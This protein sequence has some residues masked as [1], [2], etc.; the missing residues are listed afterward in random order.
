METRSST[1]TRAHPWN[2]S[3]SQEQKCDFVREGYATL[4]NVLK[5]AKEHIDTVFRKGRFTKG[6]KEDTPV[7]SSGTKV[8]NSSALTDLCLGDRNVA[9]S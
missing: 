9:I 6:P 4:R 2:M 1:T 3:L 7:L 5:T 8:Q